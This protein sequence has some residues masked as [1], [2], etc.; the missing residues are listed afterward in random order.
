M[1]METFIVEAWNIWKERK[2]NGIVSNVESWVANFKAD[3]SLLVHRTRPHLPPF[4]TDLVD[5]LSLRWGG[6]PPCKY[7]TV[8]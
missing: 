3:Y 5:N 2:F 6:L 1:F 7:V 8:L 4:I